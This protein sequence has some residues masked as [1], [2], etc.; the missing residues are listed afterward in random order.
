[1]A[2]EVLAID[3]DGNICQNA[4]SG[5]KGVPGWMT[6]LIETCEGQITSVYSQNVGVVRA[7]RSL[8]EWLELVETVTGSS[9]STDERNRW[10]AHFAPFYTEFRSPE[11]RINEGGFVIRFVDWAQR[12]LQ[13]RWYLELYG[14]TRG[15]NHLVVPLSPP[16]DAHPSFIRPT[17]PPT[18]GAPLVPSVLPFHT[19]S[20][21]Q[22]GVC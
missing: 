20:C 5:D 9:L 19:V 10:T 12:R 22:D 14:R 4:A 13:R 7:T 16:L 17:L 2:F 8:D 3:E 15:L 18:M 1:M 11:R 6:K 21:G